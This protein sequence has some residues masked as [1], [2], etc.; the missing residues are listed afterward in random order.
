[1]EVKRGEQESNKVSERP[2][3]SVKEHSRS[4]VVERTTESSVRT[5]TQPTSPGVASFHRCI[6]KEL[7]CPP[8][9]EDC[10][11]QVVWKGMSTTHRCLGDES[12]L[13]SSTVVPE[14]S[15]GQDH[16]SNEQQH[17][18]CLL[19]EQTRRDDFLCTKSSGSKDT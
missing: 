11:R 5:S 6:S 14:D 7:G 3:T 19:L 16:N 13:V 2:N 18:S 12:S 15:F 1:M 17:F 8:K 10:P 4:T 9:R